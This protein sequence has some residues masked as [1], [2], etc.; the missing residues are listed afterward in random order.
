MSVSYV[1]KPR[2]GVDGDNQ[3]KGVKQAQRFAREPSPLTF[4][5]AGAYNLAIAAWCI[6]MAMKHVIRIG[7]MT[8]TAD[9]VTPFNARVMAKVW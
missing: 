9:H 1:A 7:Q 4:G 3:S 5:T 2:N 8:A 6:E